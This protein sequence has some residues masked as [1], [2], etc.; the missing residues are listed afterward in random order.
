[1][2]S[3]NDEVDK[4]YIELFKPTRTPVSDKEFEFE[5]YELTN[6]QLKG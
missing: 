6:E 3:E 2:H 5:L 4:N 1:M